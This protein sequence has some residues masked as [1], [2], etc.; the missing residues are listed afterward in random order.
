VKP[1]EVRRHIKA[2][3][4]APIYLLEGDDLHSRNELAQEFAGVVDEGL[5]AFNVES[6]YANEAT[7]AA[8]R[9]DLIGQ[10]LTAAR[11]LPMM[12]PRRVLIVHQA[13]R[14][15]SPK[16]GKDDEPEAPAPAAATKKKQRTLTPVEQ[17][18]EYF[19]APEPMATVVFV[20]GD[21]DLNRR[22][23]K[24]ARKHAVNVECGTLETPAE[25]SKW[26]QKR[27][28][29]ENLAIEP[30]AIS[31]LLNSIGLRNDRIP[32]GPLRAELEKLA[33]YA[34]GEK[35][36]TVR[37]VQDLVMPQSE[38]GEDFA[39]G[40]AIWNGNASAALREVAAEL[41]LGKP[42]FMVLGLIRAAVGRLRSDERVRSG[43]DAVFET[44][45]AIKSSMGEPRF[46]LERLVI[47]LCT[48][49]ARL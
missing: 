34:T 11:T 5:Q 44:D 6:F 10:L 49:G 18:E 35:S 37:H 43:L 20:A 21:L 46:L 25:A 9:D 24:L 2:A 32:L 27:L 30:Q 22:L 36:I 23:V 42:A 1:T 48:R 28:E 40:R 14:L 13:E 33:L 29:T 19:A 3:E 16:K 12:A 47:E 4:T 45:L 8:A 31:L 15:L 41:D 26:I 39:L 17:L 7:T 38:P